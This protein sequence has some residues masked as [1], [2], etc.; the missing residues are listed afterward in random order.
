MKTKIIAEMCYNHCGNMDY[1]KSMIDE[2]ASLGLWGV[3]FQKWDIDAFPEDV[4]NQV[5]TD[6]HAFAKTYIE[7]RKKLELSIEQLVELKDFAEFK[8]LVF[9]C[10]GKD[11]A[12]LQLLIDN[13]IRNIKLPSQRLLD[14]QMYNYIV[15]NSNFFRMLLVSTGMHYENEIK[16]AEIIKIANVV[17]HCI[18]DYPAKLN[19]CDIAFMRT[20][21]IYNGYSSHEFEGRAIKYAVTCGAEYI[22][23]HYT[24]DRTMKGADHIVSSDYN[25]IKRIIEEI[26]EAEMIMGSGKRDLNKPELKNRE[27]YLNF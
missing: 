20:A 6:K 25:E 4:K 5:R 2:A 10:S 19:D 7:H 8:K 12:S 17:M 14:K 16:K 3:K 23:R 13:D 15:N 24:L 27:F 26:K 22:E 9:I 1:A 11:M 21:G 18:T